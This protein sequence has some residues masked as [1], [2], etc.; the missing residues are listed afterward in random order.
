M[1]RAADIEDGVGDFNRLQRSSS[2]T[3]LAAA[4]ALGLF[5]GALA[6]ARGGW[7]FLPFAGWVTAG[8]AYLV[9][10]WTA[11][12][13]LAPPDVVRLSQREDS[14]RAFSDAFLVL[15]SAAAL[16]A[17]AVILFSSR[18][19]RGGALVG[20]GVASVV[21]SWGVLH[22]AFTLKYARLYYAQGGG[23]DFKQD[24][25]PTYPDFAYLAFTVGM[26]FQ[27]SDTD[28][29]SPK[30]RSLVLAHSLAA[31]LFGAIIIAVTVNLLAGLG[32]SSG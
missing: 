17:V 32:G 12:W 1:T 30:M 14:S 6:A 28:I 5:V 22:T 20:L 23:I 19:G 18:S 4:S 27:V 3:R 29:S 25:Q 9:W 21:V 10:T 26:T 8:V 15:T 2:G 16:L 11:V 13:R 24:E 7:L 31:Y